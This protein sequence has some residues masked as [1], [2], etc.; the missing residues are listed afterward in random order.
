MTL[1]KDDLVI[2]NT[3]YLMKTVNNVMTRDKIFMTDSEGN[4][5]TRYDKPLWS[6]KVVPMVI[7]GTIQQIV[8]GKVDEDFTDDM[9]Y[10]MEVDGDITVFYEGHLINPEYGH[11]SVDS[12][13]ASNDEA[14]SAGK[15]FYANRN[16]V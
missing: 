12:F 16:N 14:E 4:Q 1:S 11:D 8:T 13:Y 6:F 15:T 7:C 2:G 5:W 9:Q 10:H 3:V